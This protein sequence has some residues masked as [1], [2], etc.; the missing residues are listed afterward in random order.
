MSD[1][2]GAAL[3]LPVLPRANELLADKG[4][5]A[6]WFRA[7]LA[8]RRIA[9]CIPSKSNRK[10]PISFDA[11]LLQATTQIRGHVRPPQGMAAGPHPLRPLR[12]HLLLRDLHRRSRSIL[13]VMS[14]DPREADCSRLISAYRGSDDICN[15]GCPI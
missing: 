5:D 13:V 15:V 4:Y 10:T 12:P 2:K 1:Y 7:G 6:D 11:A 9:A 14:P 3:M 8:K